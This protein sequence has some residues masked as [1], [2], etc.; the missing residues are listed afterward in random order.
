[1][2]IKNPEVLKQLDPK[3]KYHVYEV[4]NNIQQILVYDNKDTLKQCMEMLK[5]GEQAKTGQELVKMIEDNHRVIFVMRDKY[6][7]MMNARD[8]YD[9]LKYIQQNLV[10]LFDE[11]ERSSSE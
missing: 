3:K 11:V 10:F 7:A 5:M 8:T 6:D 1:M 2:K 4:R 9:R